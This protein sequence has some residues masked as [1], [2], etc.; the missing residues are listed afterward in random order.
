METQDLFRECEKETSPPDRY[1]LA[2]YIDS[3][4]IRLRTDDPYYAYLSVPGCIYE[5]LHDA[6]IGAASNRC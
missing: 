5:A 3:Q 1:W 2:D 4:N 6:A